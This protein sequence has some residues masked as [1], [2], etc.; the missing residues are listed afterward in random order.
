MNPAEP[1]KAKRRPD[2]WAWFALLL[3]VFT[4]H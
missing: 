4:G 1:L 2:P 3:A